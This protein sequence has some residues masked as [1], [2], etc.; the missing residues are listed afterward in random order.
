MPN[1]TAAGTYTKD[2]VGFENLKA[3]NKPRQIMIGGTLGTSLT[4]NYVDDKGTAR[5]LENGTVTIPYS[6]EI[7]INADLELVSVGTPNLNVTIRSN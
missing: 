1:I 3:T 7:N 2:S 5:P 6:K 4:I